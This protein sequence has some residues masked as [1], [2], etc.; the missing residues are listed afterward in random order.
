MPP[1]LSLIKGPIG[2]TEI[3]FLG[4]GSAFLLAV[5][6]AFGL[7]ARGG[8]PS[9]LAKAIYAYFLQGI[10]VLLMTISGLPA[11]YGVMM[12]QKLPK[13]GYLGLLILFLIGGFLFLRFESKAREVD[14]HVS[15]IPSVIFRFTLK[16]VAFFTT[17]AACLQLVLMVLYSKYPFPPQTWVGPVI[18]LAYGLFLVWT[19]HESKRAAHHFHSTQVKKSIPVLRAKTK[20]K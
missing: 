5:L 3:L 19:T 14:T 12:D 15:E 16:L 6:L 18:L 1:F 10:G 8:K 13:N 20:K 2:L 11:M 7:T 4:L 9:E 17:L